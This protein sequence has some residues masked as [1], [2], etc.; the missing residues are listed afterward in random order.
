MPWLVL[1]LG[2]IV[3]L[4][5]YFRAQSVPARRRSRR[6]RD[7]EAQV[8]AGL[9]P[10]AGDPSDPHAVAWAVLREPIGV[11]RWLDRQAAARHFRLGT[12]FGIGWSLLALGMYLAVFA[13]PAAPPDLR[14][15]GDGAPAPVD[16]G[17]DR[18]APAAQPGGA[19]AVTPGTGGTGTTTRE[20][21]GGSGAQPQP[22]PGQGA[23]GQPGSG[24]ATPPQPA[25]V[26]V[27]IAEGDTAPRVAAKLAGAG[28]IRDRE[29]F[30]R[31]LVE[32]KKD[33]L[34]RPG[35]FRILPG[36][37]VDAVI[38]ILTRS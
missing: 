19:G 15:S 31:R 11:E 21:A 10:A 7:V 24:P 3:T 33:T 28:V 23:S 27:T 26:T 17:P 13:T 34:L 8:A 9:D 35:T 29:E 20:P 4:G 16:A 36:Q 1:A 37:S 30:L 6:A 25:P 18:T 22:G 2:T 12:L 5:A 14:D 38:D 32:R